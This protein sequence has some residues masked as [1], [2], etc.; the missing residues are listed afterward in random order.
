[1]LKF[2]VFSYVTLC[3]GARVFVGLENLM[4]P[5]LFEISGDNNPVIE[6]CDHEDVNIAV[7]RQFT[8]VRCSIDSKMYVRFAASVFLRPL[9]KQLLMVPVLSRDSDDFSV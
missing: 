6:I 2:R 5:A 3:R 9:Y 7:C 4:I 8:S 1:M